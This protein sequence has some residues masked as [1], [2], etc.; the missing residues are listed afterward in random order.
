MAEQCANC[1]RSNLLQPDIANFQCLACGALTSIATGKVVT[2][3]PQTPDLSNAGFPVVEL[4]TGIV[5]ADANEYHPPVPLKTPAQ[6]A[7]E[8]PES[9]P[10]SSGTPAPEPVVEP[11]AI[12][13][14]ALTPE[15][16]A[17]VEAIVHQGG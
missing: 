14:S 15:Q 12:D 5:Q 8:A 1:G 10:E 9:A 11:E 16:V 3:Q 7:A 13:L 6:E 2:P 17:A 4:S